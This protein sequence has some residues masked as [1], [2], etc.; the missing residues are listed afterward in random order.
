VSSTFPEGYLAKR[1]ARVSLAKKFENS[2][3]FDKL[4]NFRSRNR[5][6]GRLQPDVIEQRRGML[7]HVAKFTAAASVNTDPVS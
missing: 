6:R 5:S 2:D 3:K 1:K 4:E 7:F